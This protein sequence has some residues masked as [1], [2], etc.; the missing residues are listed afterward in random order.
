MHCRN[1]QSQ[2][3][4]TANAVG[5]STDTKLRPAEQSACVTVKIALQQLKHRLF[6]PPYYF[7]HR[8]RRDPKLNLSL[9]MIC[10]S[11]VS[12]AH[13]AAKQPVA[14]HARRTSNVLHI[15]LKLNVEDTIMNTS[16]TNLNRQVWRSIKCGMTTIRRVMGF[17]R[18]SP[19]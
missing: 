9:T 6:F 12:G 1:L 5:L 7:P 14:E 10:S 3:P 16:T 4:T 8:H 15:L 19:S 13:S 17:V 11:H 2:N 18:T